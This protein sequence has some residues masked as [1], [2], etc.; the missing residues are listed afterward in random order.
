MMAQFPP[1]WQRYF[2]QAAA[3]AASSAHS[4]FH[5]VPLV[6]A[7]ANR[8]GTGGAA[9]PVPPRPP[10]DRRPPPPEPP[11]RPLEYAWLTWQMPPAMRADVIFNLRQTIDWRTQYCKPL[12]APKTPHDYTRFGL[13]GEQLVPAGGVTVR[14]KLR[15]E[16]RETVR[17]ME[18]E[19]PRLERNWM[20]AMHSARLGQ[21]CAELEQRGLD[22]LEEVRCGLSVLWD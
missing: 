3:P 17:V 7:D 15:A 22:V 5:R 20:L 18:G 14:K 19:Q 4:P 12:D 1:H 2:A 6:A 9:P 11:R 10:V 13:M 8:R 16:L 21:L